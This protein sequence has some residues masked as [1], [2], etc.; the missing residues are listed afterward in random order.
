MKL[1]CDS[2]RNRPS[3]N[4]LGSAPE[5]DKVSREEIV[6]EGREELGTGEMSRV[7]GARV[8]PG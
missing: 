8:R 3:L 2:S 1:K 4:T 6:E 7:V 5:S